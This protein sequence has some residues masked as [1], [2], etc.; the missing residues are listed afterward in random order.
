MSLFYETK[1]IYENHEELPDIFKAAEG[2][3][4]FMTRCKTERACVSYFQRKAEEQGFKPLVKGA[5]LSAGDKFYI[6]NRGRGI[7]LGIMGKRPAEEGLH[8]AATHIDSPRIDLKPCPLYESEGLALLKTHYYGGIKKYQWTTIPLALE[9]VVVLQDGTTVDLS[10]NDYTFTISEILIHLSHDQMSKTADKVIEGEN[11]RVI[12]GN[13]PD[14]NADKEKVKAA[15]LKIL[16]EKYGMTEKDFISAELTLVP[17]FD[18]AELGFDKSLI[19]AYGHDD[20]ICAYTAFEALMQIKEIP[21]KTALVALVDKEEIG[22][23][24]VSGMQS[25]FMELVFGRIAPG[26]SLP[27]LCYN[28]KCLSADVNAALD[29]L[30]PAPTEAQN[31]CRLSHGPC[32]TKYTGARGKSSTSDASAETMSYFTRLFDANGIRWQTGLLGAVDAGGGG[33]VAK[34]MA[35]RNIDTV[36]IGIGLLSMHAPFE[37]AS[38]ADIY[39]TIRAF[40]AFLK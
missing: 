9:G 10:D 39:E 28:S 21:E 25:Q 29:P 8:I 32:I 24:G 30:Y 20:R 12:A 5:E 36:D 4:D 11:L 34:Y 17:K 2:Y 38:K 19:G 16:N 35:N 31:C 27:E 18:P 3:I 22:S 40:H 6:I 23:D 15:V 37:V 7:F 13:I 1:N 14:M 26:V 33:T